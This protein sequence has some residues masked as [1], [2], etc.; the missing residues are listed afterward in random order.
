MSYIKK[1]T[2][3]KELE[4]GNGYAMRWFTLDPPQLYMQP[5]LNEMFEPQTQIIKVLKIRS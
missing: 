1:L 2:L 4:L 5:N 3:I